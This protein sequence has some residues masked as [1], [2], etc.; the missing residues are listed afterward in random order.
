MS[1]TW[2][3]DVQ[4]TAL[5]AGEELSEEFQEK[6]KTIFEAAINAKV[7]QIKEQLEAQFEEKFAEEVAAA[8]EHSQ[9]VLILILSMFLMSGLKRITRSRIWS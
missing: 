2:K 4:C 7:A 9:K 1:M 3:I 8:K 6:A 5:I